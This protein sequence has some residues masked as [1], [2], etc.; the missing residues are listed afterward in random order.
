MDLAH[1]SVYLRCAHS[2][3]VPFTYASGNVPV[4]FCI[5]DDTA[6]GYEK[7]KGKQRIGTSTRNITRK[8]TINE[9]RKNEDSSAASCNIAARMRDVAPL[10]CNAHV[11]EF[12]KD[13]SNSIRHKTA[14]RQRSF[15][16]LKQENSHAISV[17]SRFV[18]VSS[19]SFLDFSL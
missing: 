14:T 16:I 4:S 6:A 18:V 19:F 8:Q 12:H 1:C 5:S 15:F 13:I 7:L 2:T 17:L 3:D 11:A 9:E 10:Y